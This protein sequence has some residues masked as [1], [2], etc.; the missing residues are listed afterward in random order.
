MQYIVYSHNCTMYCIMYSAVLVHTVLYSAV[1]VHTV[2]YSAA[3]VHTLST[4]FKNI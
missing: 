1:L 4:V 3:L 2:L